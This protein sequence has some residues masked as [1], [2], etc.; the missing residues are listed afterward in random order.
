MS[1][2][3]G[4]QMQFSP[5]KRPEKIKWIH[6]S[7]QLIIAVQ[8]LCYNKVKLIHQFYKKKIHLPQNV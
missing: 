4:D 3:Q 6:Y 7:C 8:E 2:K 5:E 1:K